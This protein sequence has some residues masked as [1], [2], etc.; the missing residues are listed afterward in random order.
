M[1]EKVI[2]DYLKSKGLN[3]YAIAGLMGNLKAESNLDPKNLQN[4]F[5]KKFGMT[6]DEYVNGVDNG[7]YNNFVHDGAGFGLAQWTY[8]SRKQ[9]LLNF[10]KEKKTSIGDL[11]MQLDFLYTEL[12][13]GY[14]SVWKALLNA[15]S[16]LEASNVV[17]LKF[18]K[19]ANQ[20]EA[21]QHARE[22][23]GIKFYEAYASKQTENKV[24]E[25][26]TAVTKG[27]TKMK[28]YSKYI[29]ST[30]THYISNSGSDEN[31]AYKNGKAGDQTGH[32]WEL[33]S[34]YN[35]PWTVVLRYEKDPRV[36]WLMANLSCAAALNNKIGYDQNQRGTYWTQLKA[37]GYNPE[38]I[39]VACEE[40]CTA[41]VTANTKACGHILGIAALENLSTS[42]YSATMKSNFVK[43]GFTALTASK[44]LTSFKHLL[45]GDVLLYEGHH[46]AANVTLGASVKGSYVV[47]DM[48]KVPEI[49][50]EEAKPVKVITVSGDPIGKATA[51]Q[52]MHIR[53]DSNT[54]GNSL[55]VVSKGTVVDV[56]ELLDNG[57][58][59]VKVGSL[60]GYTSNRNNAYYTYVANPV[61]YAAQVVGGSLNV[62]KGSGTNYGVKKVIHN[63][64]K[65]TVYKEQNGF[66][67]IDEKEN[68]WCSLKYLK[69][70]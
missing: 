52:G 44:Y 54:D 45:P 16:I 8:Y 20:S 39:T 28:D 30:G 53:D 48:S 33:K 68:L 46:A 70:V 34:W 51:K 50:T 58:M 11:Q 14:T 37:A 60:V 27:G 40:D 19:P 41:G 32:E 25:T 56:Y 7:T 12:S 3:D 57:W 63:G 49:K 23:N 42:I 1:N 5:N 31:K 64:D 26:T 43:A 67:C 10:C 29:N 69:K 6:D 61:G 21:V 47:P 9:K 59:K 13:T 15:T 65:V 55:K 18:E 4:S 17:L 38:N 36:G 2:W 24:V 22:N 66:G 62:R 35:R